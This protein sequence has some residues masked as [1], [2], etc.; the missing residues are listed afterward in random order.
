MMMIVILMMIASYTNDDDVIIM[1]I[2]L[3]TNDNDHCDFLPDD[4]VDNG[5]LVYAS[6]EILSWTDGPTN[7][8]GDS[9]N[10]VVEVECKQKSGG[11]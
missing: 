6:A 8:Q 7:E 5:R 3:Y 1:M 9:K 4:E 10:W 2:A 11:L